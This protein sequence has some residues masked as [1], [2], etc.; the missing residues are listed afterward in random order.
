MKKKGILIAIIVLIVLLVLAG[1]AFAY[2]YFATDLLKTDKE[3]FQKYAVQM[4]DSENGFIPSILEEYGNKKSTTAYENNGSI[5]ANTTITADTSENETLQEVIKM[6][7]IANNA[8]ITFS[9]KVDNANK[10]AEQ[11]ITLNYTDTVN[12]PFMYKQDGDTYGLR[13]DIIAPRYVAFENNNLQ[14]FAQ[15]MGVTDVSSIPNK[16][17]FPEIQSLKF[18]D[19]EKTHILEQYVMPVFEGLADEKF[20]RAENTDG[21]TTYTLSITNIELRNIEVQMLETLKND[22]M[23]L[24][25]INTILQEIYSVSA[26]SET[27]NG[28]DATNAIEITAEDIDNTIANLN[29]ENL[30]EVMVAISVTQN[31]GVTNRI[32]ATQEGTT[33]TLGKEQAEGSVTYELTVLVPN[34][35][36][37]SVAEGAPESATITF[38]MAYSGLNTNNTTE[39]ISMNLTAPGL[40]SQNYSYTNALTFGNTVTFDAFPED[41]AYLN[42][43]SAEEI[44]SFLSQV[45]QIIAQNNENQMNQIGF[46]TDMINPI[47]AWFVGPARAMFL[48]NMAAS[49][50]GSSQPDFSSAEAETFNSTFTNYEGE[51]RGVNVK[52]LCDSVR[53]HNLT[54]NSGEKVNIKIGEATATTATDNVNDPVAIKDQIDATKTYNVTFSY[55]ASTGKICEIG[56]TEAGT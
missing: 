18:T 2:I 36:E 45:G 27:V 34:D 49:A 24:N 41:T 46:P 16:I 20:T 10:K 3:L 52:S 37:E 6:F 39:T 53:I 56:V 38:T 28:E 35:D 17:E 47:I 11:N 29:E 23:M 44:V 33:I 31:D 50:I 55:D 14:E 48:Y 51:Q 43:S 30:K 19:E 54:A 8:N 25:K 32:S 15:K 9:G 21:S 7:D 42:N 40:Y 4:G 5:S 12:F 1:G 22:T 26:L 13:A